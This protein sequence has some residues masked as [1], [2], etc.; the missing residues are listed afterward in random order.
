MEGILNI[1]AFIACI[2]VWI[3]FRKYFRIDSKSQLIDNTIP[4]ISIII[5]ARN[6]AA[7]I[8][9]L[10]TSLL[11]LENGPHEIIVV[12]DQLTDHTR[13][14]AESFSV[15]ILSAGIRPEGWIGKS[16]ACH[17]GAQAATGD[18]LLFTDA[19]TV[20][21]PQAL[22]LAWDWMRRHN[23]DLVSTPAYHLN[24]LWWEKLLGPFHCLVH[25]GAS[26]YD[27]Q[28]TQN[29]YAVGQFLL[30]KSAV[31]QEI[32]GHMAI[33]SELA[34][35]V[36]LAQSVMSSGYRYSVYNGRPICRVQMYR[37]FKE[38]IQGW[39]RLMRL[40]MTGLSFEIAFNSLLPLLALNGLNLI[41][42][43]FIQWLPTL[44]TLACFGVVQRRIGNFSVL[45]VVL[46]P[47][48]V[49][50]FVGIGLY[51]VIAEWI[52]LPIRWKGRLYHSLRRAAG[53]V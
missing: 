43:G 25:A 5:P 20:H 10:L 27:K 37:S 22:A 7:N 48:S 38:Y 21:H 41:G 46:F 29:A 36:A 14:L 44:I 53:G 30:I 52:G 51:S 4:K 34:E 3:R 16:W 12:D 1:V 45:G 6:E 32:G 39:A 18:V 23:S 49:M 13:Q 35:D 17:V 42:P 50:L 8:S 24:K 26:P 19:D 33:R 28:S 31:Y 15:K 47:I 40:G 9:R 11:Q 2:A